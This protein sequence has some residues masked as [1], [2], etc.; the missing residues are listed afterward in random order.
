MFHFKYDV[1]NHELGEFLHL[2]IVWIIDIFSNK[3]FGRFKVIVSFLLIIFLFL[4]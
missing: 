1:L 2:E 4:L 3:V